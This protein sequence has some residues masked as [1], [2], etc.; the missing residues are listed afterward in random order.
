MAGII[1]VTYALLP[2]PA[3]DRLAPAVA[4]AL[5][6]ACA[7]FLFFNFPPAKIFLGDSGST[8]LGLAI[9]F[10]GLSFYHSP[11]ATGPRLLFPWVVAGLPLF[12]AALAV[13]RRLRG[14]VSPFFG[15]R[16]HF[17]DLIEARGVSARKVALMCYAATALLGLIGVIGVRAKPVD[18]FFLAS[19]G[20]VTLVVTA[21]RMGA[22]RP[23]GERVQQRPT[24][25]TETSH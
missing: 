1:G 4:W 25:L 9:A 3:G 11:V 15:D 13:I 18:F 12:D 19:T 17:Y 23:D 6:G 2:W 8:A 21:I 22:L 10:L 20:V 16:R 5:A 24:A 7:G 14:H